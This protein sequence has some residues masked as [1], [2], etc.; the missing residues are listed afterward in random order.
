MVEVK[1]YGMTDFLLESYRWAIEKDEVCKEVRRYVRES[2]PAKTNWLPKET[3]ELCSM[4]ED[5][6]EVKG[7]I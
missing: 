3:R 7:V 1:V 6:M 2:W 4:K 5:L